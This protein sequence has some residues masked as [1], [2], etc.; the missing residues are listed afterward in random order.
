MNTNDKPK[1]YIV[2]DNPAVRDAIRWLMK[3][4]SLETETFSLAREFLESYIP[5]TRGCL[6][7]DI[8]MPEM[9]GLELLGRLSQEGAV[10]PVIVITG[11]ADIQ[12]AVRAMKSGTFEFLEKPFN[13]QVLLDAVQA[14]LVKY[15]PI[16]D[17]LDRRG[18]I[19]QSLGTLSRREEDVLELLKLGKPNKA[20]ADALKLSVRTVEAHRA[21]IM[22][23]TSARS[24]GELMEMARH[25][26]R[27]EIG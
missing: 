3:Q 24:L 16:W 19:N 17:E 4:V 7:L 18:E 8:R 15:T 11:H 20:I 26:R 9:S 5:G 25:F 23:K 14:A 12:L 10:L 1:V 2:D 22:D 6:I 21:A 27:R 13:D